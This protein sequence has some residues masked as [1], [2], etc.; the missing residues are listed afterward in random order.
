M[1]T[2]SARA[3]F[4]PCSPPPPS[5][6]PSAGVHRSTQPSTRSELA[7]AHPPQRADARQPPVRRRAARVHSLSHSAASPRLGLAPAASAA[8]LSSLAHHA[9]RE[10]VGTRQDSRSHSSRSR[11]T[12]T[13]LSTCPFLSGERAVAATTSLKMRWGPAA[14]AASAA[15]AAAVAKLAEDV[16]VVDDDDDDDDDACDIDA[17]DLSA[18]PEREKSVPSGLLSLFQCQ[19]WEWTIAWE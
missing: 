3:S 15:S 13:V 5:P 7:G 6:S 12:P 2:T 1:T 16:V 4:I 19:G 10:T 18:A 9:G 8:H 14:S 11:E 17:R